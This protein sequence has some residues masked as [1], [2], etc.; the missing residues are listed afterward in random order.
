MEYWRDI[1][2]SSL[3]LVWR[4]DQTC[5]NNVVLTVACGLCE[6]RGDII[7]FIIQVV[8]SGNVTWANNSL[9]DFRK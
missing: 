3:L 7:K 1:P 8:H 9:G 5:Q 4:V 2:L 6:A